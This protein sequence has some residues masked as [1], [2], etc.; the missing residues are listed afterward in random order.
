M[1]IKLHQFENG[2]IT[3]IGHS[4]ENQSMLLLAEAI[5]RAG[6]FDIHAAQQV[7]EHCR[8]DNTHPRVIYLLQR[9][10]YFGLFAVE[11]I[12]NHGRGLGRDDTERASRQTMASSADII[13]A[14]L[15]KLAFTLLA[16]SRSLVSL[17]PGRILLNCGG[18]CSHVR[19]VCHN[20]GGICLIKISSYRVGVG[21]IFQRLDNYLPM[22]S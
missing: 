2:F 10:Q 13:A 15:R 17:G 20:G 8:F 4:L 9:V 14:T 21:I 18:R 11:I 7:L 12:S 5:L 19:V 6:K 22:F 16:I 1:V 3:Q